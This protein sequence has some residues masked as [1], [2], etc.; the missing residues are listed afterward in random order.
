MENH[1]LVLPEHLNHYGYLFGGNLLKWVDEYAWIAATLDHPGCKFVTIGMDRV[2][3]HKPICKGTILRFDTTEVERG[4]SSCRYRV[5]VFADDLD[6]GS[7]QPVFTTQVS[8]VC[9]DD[10]GRKTPIP[11]K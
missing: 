10:G 1:K 4:T 3:F 2:E 11:T 5:E 8:F 7:E 6:T 9:L